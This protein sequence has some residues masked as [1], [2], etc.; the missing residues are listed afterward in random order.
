MKCLDIGEV[1]GMMLWF[2]VARGLLAT[3]F[4]DV[5]RVGVSGETCL[6]SR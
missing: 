3:K 1:L 6:G 2:R 4:I 5:Y